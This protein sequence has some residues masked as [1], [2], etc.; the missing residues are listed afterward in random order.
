MS[1]VLPY[2][3]STGALK[4]LFQK[5]KDA[6]TP[7]RFNYDYLS[8]ELGVTER[9]MI[10]LLKKLGFLSDE[11]KPNQLYRDFRNPDMS[12]I[13]MATAM[14]SAYEPLYRRNEF[15]HSLNRE[16][17]IQMMVDVT[18]KDH[19][20]AA[21]KAAFTTFDVL[22]SEADF[23]SSNPNSTKVVLENKEP[24]PLKEQT[25]SPLPIRNSAVGLNLGYTVNLNLP[26]TTN[27]EVYNAIFKSLNEHFLKHE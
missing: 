12:G 4:R 11:G 19:D 8:T 15:A 16:K 20:S 13:A 25:S 21:T 23:K 9:A 17:L 26:E 24:V 18:G 5:I 27:I 2:V 3:N 10:P 14:R 7:E 22:R 6:P 1:T